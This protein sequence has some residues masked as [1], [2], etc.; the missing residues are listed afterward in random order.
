MTPT[1]TGA[2]NG[3]QAAEAPA[4]PSYDDVMQ[5]V[6]EGLAASSSA[7]AAAGPSSAA[8]AS[9]EMG[10]F[11]AS[12]PAAPSEEQPLLVPVSSSGGRP[13][14][15]ATAE[16]SSRDF[17][18]SLEYK[19][20]SK[21][22]SSSDPLLNTDARALRRFITET[23]ERPRVTVVVEGSHMEERSPGM[24]PRR[25]SDAQQDQQQGGPYWNQGGESCREKVVDFRFSLELTPFIHDRG[26]LYTARQ[27]SGEPY[28]IDAI[29]QDYVGAENVLKEIVVQKR[30][31]WDYDAVRQQIIAFIRG[32]VGYP[33]TVAVTFPMENDRISIKTHSAIGRV[34]RHP[35]TSFL[36]FLTCAC[37]VG[38]PLRRLATQRWRNKLMSDFVVL[39]APH[40][41]VQR[42]AD[43]MRSQVTWARV[44]LGIVHGPGH[45]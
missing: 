27:R 8:P 38:W 43:F 41:Y 2:S 36:C 25:D 9:V 11:S 3:E 32:T 4:P 31:I 29:L 33:H 16:Q 5:S 34:W 40:D 26:S 18:S 24:R 12:K 35:V 30:A 1:T 21:G 28:D 42:N 10:P 37:L 39:V 15:A 14:A 45:A 17:F 19:R 44:P 23:N 22:Y 6:H 20:T 13:T 7:A